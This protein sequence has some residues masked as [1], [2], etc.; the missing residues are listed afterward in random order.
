MGV[1]EGLGVAVGVGEG[2]A[3]LVFDA[4]FPGALAPLLPPPPHPAIKLRAR[5]TTSKCVQRRD[6]GNSFKTFS[7]RG[8]V[9]VLGYLQLLTQLR[10]RCFGRNGRVYSL[11]DGLSVD[12]RQG[13]K[14]EHH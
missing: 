9:L 13:R 12:Q 1:G 6:M 7:L 11:A 8:L 4:P 5:A 2:E 14:I 10:L 3:P